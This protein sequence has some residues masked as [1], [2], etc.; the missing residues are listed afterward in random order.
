MIDTLFGWYIS[1]QLKGKFITV[2]YEE[3]IVADDSATLSV[4]DAVDGESLSKYLETDNFILFDVLAYADPGFVKVNAIPDND[5]LKQFRLEATKNPVRV[6]IMPP[7]MVEVDLIL[8]YTNESQPNDLYISFAAMRIPEDKMDDFTMLSELI[9]TSIHNIDIQTLQIGQL[10]Q[11]QMATDAG[12]AP[13]FT[14]KPMCP[15]G[16]YYDAS[17]GACVS[18]VERKGFCKR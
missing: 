8:D 1:E 18:E 2:T 7:K 12:T 9:P 10:L 11:N 4:A 6:P 14:V 3:S 13:P 5:T 15:T 16:Y 17:K